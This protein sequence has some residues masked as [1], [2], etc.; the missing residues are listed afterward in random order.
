MATIQAKP[1]MRDVNV[2]IITRAC[3]TTGDD[4]P[5]V[6]VRLIDKKKVTFDIVTEK[7]TFFD[8]RN[9]IGRNLGKLPIVDM[10][11]AFDPSIE[12]GPSRKHGTLQQFFESCLL[13]ARDPEALI[14]I[15]KLLYHRD[16]ALKDSAVNSLQKRKTGKE[17]RMNI[18]IGDYE[19][20]SVIL[21]LRSDVKILTK[22]T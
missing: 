15:E 17:M 4:G 5:R 14:E 16:K 20:D 19:V 3:A 11:F 10:P 6:Q 1:Q 2:G 13:L 21:D 12:A 22:Q 8:A 7:Y 9:E 18:Q